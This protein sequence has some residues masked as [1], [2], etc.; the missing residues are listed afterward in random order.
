MQSLL[1]SINALL[2]SLWC[3]PPHNSV[4]ESCNKWAFRNERRCE[5]SW[6]ERN[7]ENDDCLGVRGSGERELDARDKGGLLMTLLSLIFSQ[8]KG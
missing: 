6:A 4:A 7:C 1:S 3:H 5:D 8:S 2:V